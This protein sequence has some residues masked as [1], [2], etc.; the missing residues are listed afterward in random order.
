MPFNGGTVAVLA[1]LRDNDVM[2][3]DPATIRWVSA[4]PIT[5][6]IF[7]PGVTLADHFFANARFF[8][9]VKITRD[10]AS[11]KRPRSAAAQS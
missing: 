2:Q 11:G 4:D 8:V 10:I 1:T 3:S 9:R 7:D 6:K 5:T